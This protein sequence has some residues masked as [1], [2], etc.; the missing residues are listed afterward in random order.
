M[1]A[2]VYMSVLPDLLKKGFFD[3]E[4]LGRV[5]M[6]KVF[7]MKRLKLIP[8]LNFYARSGMGKK[9]GLGIRIREE[10]PGSYFREL[11]NNLG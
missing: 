11:R 1:S 2:R 3:R 6:I 4:I 7:A 8:N 5:S 9:S 10:Q